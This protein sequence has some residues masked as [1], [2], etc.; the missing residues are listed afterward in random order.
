[1][2]NNNKPIICLFVHCF[3]PA[4]GGL[5]YLTGEIKKLLDDSYEVH[6]IT[7]QGM[8]LDSYKTF[9]N[10]V[11]ITNEPHIH[12]L[13]INQ[14]LQRL[15]NKLFGK[16]IFKLGIFSPL[17]FGPILKYSPEIIKIIANSSL[18]IG[19]GM[20]TKMF[21]D[22]YLFARK[23]SKKLILHPSYHNVSYY[24]HCPQ[25]QQA[26]SF[27]NKIIYQTQQEFNGLIQNYKIDKNKLVQLTYNEYTTNQIKK[28]KSKKLNPKKNT[29]G[30]IGQITHR[31][32]LG[33]FKEYLDKYPNTNL[34]FAGTHTNSSHE[35]E[36]LFAKYLKNGRLNIVYDF[37]NKDKSKMYKNI[38]IFVNPSL[39]ES[40]GIVNFEAIY[41]GIPLIV[42]SQSA[43]A[44]FIDK[45]SQFIT[46]N[47]L[48]Q[49][50]LYHQNN[51]NNQNDILIKYNQDIYRTHLVEIINNLLNQND[52]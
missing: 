38:D 42:H 32:N 7:G 43:F 44:E 4:K 17:Y 24:N 12:R 26:L 37:D 10:Y 36:T 39:E 18:I 23:Y 21:N 50:I 28:I 51:S 22:S 19:T 52:E 27:A 49:A 45:N 25:F 15:F 3:P 14:P 31:K 2:T 35:T 11:T 16:I 1:M 20:P 5:E 29:L 33:V 13:P 48:H 41:H 40:L 34:F 30:F 6:I 9:D 46:I 8:S 47:D